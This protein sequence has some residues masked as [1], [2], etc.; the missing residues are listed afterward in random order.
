MTLNEAITLITD[1]KPSRFTDDLL[2]RWI[3]ELDGQL[4][5]TIMS[6]RVD[7]PVSAPVPYTF[8]D[9]AET[10]LLVAAPYDMIYI[11]WLRTKIDYANQDLDRYN[12]SVIMYNSY[13]DN[14][15]AS[16]ARSH[17][18]SEA[19]IDVDETQTASQISI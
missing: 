18:S 5:D 4:Y 11:E 15:A 16:Y 2:V 13:H 19:T 8:E 17:A 3:S 12:N 1:L 7:A 6:G 9:D 14:F 10:V